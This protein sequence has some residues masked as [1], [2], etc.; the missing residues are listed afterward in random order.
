MKSIHP[1]QTTPTLT[2]DLRQA[3]TRSFRDADAETL[4]LSNA[5]LFFFFASVCLTSLT[6]ERVSWPSPQAMSG[7]LAIQDIA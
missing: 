2:L 4:D 6:S 3:S 7:V 1:N 5:H